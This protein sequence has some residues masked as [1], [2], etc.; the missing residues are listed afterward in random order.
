M[1]QIST[2]K[3]VSR[4]CQWWAA[5]RTTT[6]IITKIIMQ[7]WWIQATSS[8]ISLTFNSSA[9]ILP[10]R[11]LLQSFLLP[12]RITILTR[13]TMLAIV[14]ATTTMKSSMRFLL[15]RWDSQV[16]ASINCLGSK[17]NLIINFSPS[18][19]KNNIHLNTLVKNSSSNKISMHTLALKE[20]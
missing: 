20:T 10:A 2:S 4:T 15:S 12:C 7:T 13:P 3:R 6:C 5:V 14:R 8:S 9:T 1:R 18:I 19:N 11:S 16:K 17:C